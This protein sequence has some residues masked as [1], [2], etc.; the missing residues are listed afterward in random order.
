LK[1]DIAPHC[2]QL[3]ITSSFSEMLAFGIAFHAPVLFVFVL[4]TIIVIIVIVHGYLYK[5]IEFKVC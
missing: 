2:K 5:R 3:N 1:L 4:E